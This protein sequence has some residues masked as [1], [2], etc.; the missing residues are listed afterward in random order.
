[1]A[2]AEFEKTDILK[3]ADQDGQFRRK[4]SQFRNFIS[5][6]PSSPFPAEKDRYVV[7]I[8]LGCPW[9]HR[10]NILLHLK[11]LTSVIP[12]IIVDCQLVPNGWSFTGDDYSATADPLYGFKYLRDL[13][14]KADLEYTGR[15]TVPCLWDKKN[16]T[17]ISNESS[18]I[19][20]MLYSEF[21]AFVPE[22]RR[23]SV[24]PLLPK[25]LQKE[26]E[27]MNEWVYNTVNNGVYKTGF[28][29]TQEAYDEHLHVLFASLDRLEKHLEQPGHSPFL[30]GEHITEAD[31]RLFTTMIRF[32]A[33]YVT[34]FK[35]NLKMIR[36]EYPRLHDWL[37]RVYWDEG[38][39]SNCGAFKKTTHFDCAPNAII[40]AGPL[41]NILLP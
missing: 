7:Y 9:A 5:S 39:E 10:V 28:A 40:P 12:I 41:H 16:E 13:Y 8:N 4:V 33:A 21:D 36:Y 38:E 18:E 3:L 24:K 27:E 25:H 30:F 14:L 26:I 31:I 1:M 2:T 29:T 23:E 22:D 34:I 19:L 37:R 32:D 20:R 35:C 6:D 11:G 15:Y 17:I